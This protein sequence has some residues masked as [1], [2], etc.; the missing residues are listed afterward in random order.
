MHFTKTTASLLCEE[1]DNVLNV[2]LIDLHFVNMQLAAIETS[3]THK[4]CKSEVTEL[5]NE[6]M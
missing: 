4:D 3:Q 1:P 5:T 2:L 6:Y